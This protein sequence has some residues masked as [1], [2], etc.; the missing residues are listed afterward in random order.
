MLTTPKDI[1]T[2]AQTIHTARYAIETLPRLVFGLR[3]VLSQWQKAKNER[4]LCGLQFV[5]GLCVCSCFEIQ[6]N[7][8]VRAFISFIHSL[9]HF[10]LF[11]V[12]CFC[13]LNGFLV[14]IVV[15]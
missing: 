5:S 4:E 15:V 1:W 11:C 3:V 7:T 6:T 8:V 9:N 12:I 13:F 10:V 2:N 14:V